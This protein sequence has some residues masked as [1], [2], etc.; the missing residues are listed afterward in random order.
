MVKANIESED[1]HQGLQQNGKK[2]KKN[3]KHKNKDLPNKK[4][5]KN[6]ES[7][8]FDE[9][10]QHVDE[11]FEEE[12]HH[13]KNKK[14]RKHSNACKAENGNAA[15]D[16]SVSS[17]TQSSDRDH[18]TTGSVLDESEVS[19]PK[20][21]RKKAKKDRQ[22]NGTGEQETVESI[23]PCSEDPCGQGVIEKKKK[24][25]N[26]SSKDKSAVIDD[27]VNVT[28]DEMDLNQHNTEINSTAEWDE[29]SSKRKKK[30]R[31]HRKDKDETNQTHPN[32]NNDFD[33]QDFKTGTVEMNFIKEV[34]E[35]RKKNK[36]KKSK[37]YSSTDLEQPKADNE[38]R[39]CEKSDNP[40]NRNDD[41]KE[42]CVRA[43]ADRNHSTGQ[44]QTADFGDTERQNK[45]I[46][47]LGGQKSGA[48]KTQL[49][50]KF[51]LNAGSA[52]KSEKNK[53]SEREKPNMA[54]NKTQ[55]RLYQISL[56]NQFERAQD[57]N[58]NRGVGL[59][60]EKVKGSNK[61]HIDIQK[62]KSVKFDD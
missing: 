52:D 34:T 14:K 27:E 4:E 43:E 51:K 29:P 38:E 13:K 53:S 32:D 54:M 12:A 37:K 62:S 21:K 47:L 33:V 7:N 30:K 25:K 46:R 19:V 41:E 40:N 36:K 23:E 18:S 22:E 17:H 57:F 56:A 28:K 15:N 1:Q 24:P 48:D 3:K 50:Q 44:W 42:P 10:S 16:E 6:T 55:E 20:K 60:F 45:F 9:A 61:F 58:Q 35:Q 8:H 49:K 5:K 39:E 11:S 2:R 26:Y 31:K 59:G